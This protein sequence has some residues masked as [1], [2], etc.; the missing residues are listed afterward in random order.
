[1][2]VFLTDLFVCLVKKLLS[3][4]IGALYYRFSWI[5]VLRSWFV[6]LSASKFSCTSSSR[7]SDV[8]FCFNSTRIV[9]LLRFVLSNILAV[10]SLTSLCQVK[11]STHFFVDFKSKPESERSETL[12]VLS[13][14][15]C[16]EKNSPFRFSVFPTSAINRVFWLR[17]MPRHRKPA[18]D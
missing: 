5:Y 13:A 18:N 4:S 8:R 17:H 1:M 14:F 3:Q 6:A 10:L 7:E 15:C 11:F 2:F 16:V 12:P 9:G